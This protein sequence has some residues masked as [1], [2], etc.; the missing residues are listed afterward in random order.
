MAVVIRVGKFELLKA[1]RTRT[2]TCP[3]CRRQ[4]RPGDL[5]DSLVA[6]VRRGR[7]AGKVRSVVSEC[8]STEW[9]VGD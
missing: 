6:V 1:T 4:V 2:V 3:M 8:C 7:V 5:Q 9:L